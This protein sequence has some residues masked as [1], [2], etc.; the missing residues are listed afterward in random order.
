VDG[1][2]L[3]ATITVSDPPDSLITLLLFAP[4]EAPS[5]VS[6]TEL[7]RR[8]DASAP[9]VSFLTARID[10]DALAVLHANRP[11]LV[12]PLG[13]EFKLYVLGALAQAIEAGEVSWDDELTVTDDNKSLPS[14][15]LQDAPAGTTVTV[16]EAAQKMIEISDN[17]ATDLLIEHVGRD[18]VEAV[19]GPMGMG[20]VSQTKTLPFLSTRELFTLKFGPNTDRAATYAQA[21]TDDRRQI[22]DSLDEPLPAVAAIPADAPAFVD[23]IEWFASPAEIAQAHLW[24]DA[25]RLVAGLEPLGDILG[26][27]PGLRIDPA[28][29]SRFSFKGGS[30]PGVLA[31]SWLLERSDGQRFVISLQVSDPAQP[32]AES[33]IFSIA[34]GAIDL[35]AAS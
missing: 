2:P 3:V 14:G 22:V 10:G 30:E 35:V 24:L 1:T 33:E 34:Q 29:W 6:W 19:L 8:L 17:T 11:D 5:P 28:V 16:R 9:N 21:T 18:K 4:P 20:D 12:Q 13:S 25:K 26:T 23:T 7:D 31:L 27:N 32:I 15:E